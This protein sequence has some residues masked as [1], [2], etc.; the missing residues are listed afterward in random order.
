MRGLS[1]KQGFMGTFAR[2]L[3]GGGDEERSL[4]VMDCAAGGKV[5]DVFDVGYDDGG[6]STLLTFGTA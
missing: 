3:Y 2:V 4:V 6:C 5:V 1:D